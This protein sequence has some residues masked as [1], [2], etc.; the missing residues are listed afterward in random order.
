[1]ISKTINRY[2]W[3]LDTLQKKKKLT[4]EEISDLWRESGIGD[5]KPL[6][7]RTFHQHRDAIEEL[8]GVKIKCDLKD[9]Y[10]YFIDNPQA[11]RDD[12]TRRWLL[13]SFSLSNMIIA[14]HNMNGRILFENVPRGTEYLQ[15]VIES[16]QQNKVLKLD[17]QSFSEHLKTYHM[18]V[19]AMK[20]Y[21]QRWYIVGRLQEQ[22]AIRQLALDRI[23]EMEMTDDSYEVPNSFDAEKYYANT[24]GVFV[25]EDM[26]PQKVR[27]RVYGKQVEYLRTLPL[28]RSQEEVLTKHE[29]FSE[30]Q[31]RLCLNP[32]LSTQLLAMG[33]NVEVL[34]PMELREEIKRRLEDCL[35][36]YS[37]L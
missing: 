1:M 21:R 4:F 9:G 12:R 5:G 24:I 34:E 6:P 17:Y 3:L 13:N 7:L 31:Y 30:F 20:V 15:P 35:T 2:I 22:D 14:G 37:T 27:I 23:M 18:E 26:N 19:Y 33:E 10:Q 36:K 32:E 29:Q 8:F 28:H 25:N 16:M 11:M